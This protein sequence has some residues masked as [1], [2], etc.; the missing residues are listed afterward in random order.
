M[1][2][3][4]FGSL[5]AD[6]KNNG[7]IEPIV[8]FEGK[9]ID[10]RHRYEAC[11]LAGIEPRFAEYTGDDPLQFVRSLN[12]HRR[13]LSESQAAVEVALAQDWSKASA[14]GGARNKAG[15]SGVTTASR[16]KNARVSERLQKSADA[17]ARKK[18]DLAAKVVSGELTFSEACAEAGIGA[19]KKR[20]ACP[21]CKKIDA[22]ISALRGQQ[23]LCDGR[24]VAQPS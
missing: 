8:L 21:T 3:E 16:A 24:A 18:P 11:R 7:L 13:H 10:G 9:I 4:A 22:E 20:C 6:I 19:D 5:V 23:R 14:H 1:T 12:V 2:S 17:L 15:E